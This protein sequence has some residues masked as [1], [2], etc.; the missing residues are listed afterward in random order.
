MSEVLHTLS[1]PVLQYWYCSIKPMVCWYTAVRKYI[2]CWYPS[3]LW[4]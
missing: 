4:D 2:Y 1:F 3:D